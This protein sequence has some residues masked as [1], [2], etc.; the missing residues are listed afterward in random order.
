M[1]K[2]TLELM[3]DYL[4]TLAQPTR[5]K[6][7]YSL[8]GGERCVCDIVEATGEEQANVSR[9]LGVLR[10][11]GVLRCRKQGVQAFYSVADPRVF[12]L[13]EDSHGLIK[14][15]IEERLASIHA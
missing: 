14:R 4:R 2:D 11:S 12:A 1:H 15:R 8:K 7:L 5:L 13:L 9:H 10:R 6:I 3:A